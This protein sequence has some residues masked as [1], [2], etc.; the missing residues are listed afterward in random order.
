MEMWKS[1]RGWEWEVTHGAFVGMDVR[2]Y[3][4]SEEERAREMKER[5]LESM[6]IQVRAEGW[7]E[8]EAEILRLE[9]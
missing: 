9:L 1:L 4:G 7:S 5:L 2:G 6:K 3:G 8:K